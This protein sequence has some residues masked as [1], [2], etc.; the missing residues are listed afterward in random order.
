MSKF[1]FLN[2]F[3]KPQ[4]L[5]VDSSLVSDLA[6]QLG[7]EIVTTEAGVFLELVTDYPAVYCHGNQPLSAALMTD[8]VLLD[9]FEVLP[10]QERISL[11]EIVFIDA[12]TTGLS[13]ATGTVAFLVGAGQIIDNRLCVTQ[14]FLPDYPHEAAMLDAIADLVEQK[15]LVVSFNGKSFDL[16]LLETRYALKRLRSPFEEMHHIDLLHCCRRFWRGRF[17][18]STLQTLE[19]RLLG[20]YRCDDTPGY[21]I[22]QLYF[23]FLRDGDA[24]P[25][26]GVLL[27]NRMDIVT[28]LFLLCTVQRY[29]EQAETHEYYSPVDALSISRFLFRKGRLEQSCRAAEMQFRNNGSDKEK[30]ELGLHL[31]KLQKRLG[32]YDAALATLSDL[33]AARG[34]TRLYLLEEM[35]KI[36]EHKKRDLTEASRCIEKALEYLNSPLSD[37]PY[38]RTLFWSETLQKRHRRLLRRSR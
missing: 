38:D 15:Q 35:A 5:D 18:D 37:I 30:I 10:R 23:D 31:H 24:A 3:N 9:H 33:I 28:L 25:L 32:E 11:D 1:D 36:W 20:M 4:S 16:P 14:F 2:R 29:L 22:P 13:A 12:E 34:E 19:R 17:E 6:S 27:H 21:L 7:G 8:K 26:G